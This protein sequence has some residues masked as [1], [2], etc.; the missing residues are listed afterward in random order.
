MT[1]VK[2][3]TLTCPTSNQIRYV[4]KTIETLQKRLNRHISYSKR[5]K[6][7]KANWINSLLKINKEPIIEIIDECSITNWEVM[8][9]YWISQFKAW[10]YNLT[11]HTDGGEGPSGRV[12]SEETRNKIS[13][14]LM[15]HNVSEETR[16]KNRLKRI[17]Y[18][19]SSESIE[20]IRL[21]HLGRKN[22]KETILKMR[23]AKL[24]KK[25]P[26]GFSEKCSQRFTG[27]T[28]NNIRSVIQL[29]KEGMEIATFSSIT[30]ASKNTNILRTSISNCLGGK[31]KTA[32]GYIWKYNNL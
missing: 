23:K 30:S 5:E 15:G 9:Q 11:N 25:M 29:N 31:S 19:P 24:G 4:G 21:V 14:S 17:G 7:Y 8:E 10:G 1:T 12:V 18:K 28:P 13:R 6:T 3:Y 22:S 20:K 32:K 2:I 26:E 16:E 27:K